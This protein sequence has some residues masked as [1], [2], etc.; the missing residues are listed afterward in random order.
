MTGVSKHDPVVAAGGI[1]LWAFL[2]AITMP[3]LGDIDTEKILASHNHNP[4]DTHWTLYLGA[5]LQT[6]GKFGL[7]LMVPALAAFS[8][9]RVGAAPPVLRP[10]SIAPVAVP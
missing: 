9:L 8:R 10:A 5:V 3:N 7:D 1:W 6:I 4:G 2:E